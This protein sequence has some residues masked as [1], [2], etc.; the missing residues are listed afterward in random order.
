VR[1]LKGAYA[2]SERRACKV[3]SIH[4]SSYRHQGTRLAVDRAHREVVK[5]S[6]RYSYWGYRKIYELIDRV[7]CPVGRER[8]RLIRR[9]EGL[10]VAK[11]AKKKKVLGRST[12]WVYR[13]EYPNHV[14]SYD[15]VHDQT[16]D[17][18]RL[19]CLS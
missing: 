11:K 7:E 5:L 13:A 10:Q 15:F 18:R 9:R 8:V 16:I 17:G 1:Y 14:W 3:M 12:Q 2:V 19:K 4:R 6:E